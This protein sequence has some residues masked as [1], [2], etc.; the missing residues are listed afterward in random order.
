MRK[1]LA[2]KKKESYQILIPPTCMYQLQP[3]DID[4]AGRHPMVPLHNGNLA[5]N[6][7]DSANGEPWR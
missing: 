1:I 3:I 5:R 2:L 6:K 4:A 7:R